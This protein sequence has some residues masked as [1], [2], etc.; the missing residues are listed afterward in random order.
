VNCKINVNLGAAGVAGATFFLFCYIYARDD[1][2]LLLRQKY[3][4]STIKK[5]YFVLFFARFFVS[6]H[7]IS[8]R[9]L[10]GGGS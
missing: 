4:H 2:Y 1:P 3:I 8:R 6:L 10:S 9:N 5:N 7:L